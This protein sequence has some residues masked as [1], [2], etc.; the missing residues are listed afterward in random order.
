[1]DR[2]AYKKAMQDQ[3]ATIEQHMMAD[4][5]FDQVEKENV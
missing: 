4:M 3:C 5:R 2:P 1:L